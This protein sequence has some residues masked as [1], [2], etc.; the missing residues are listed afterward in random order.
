M[1]EGNKE[2]YIFGIIDILTGY[3]T[4]KAMEFYFKR[5]FYGPGISAVPPDQY[6]ERF[7]NFAEQ[8]VFKNNKKVINWMELSPK[9]K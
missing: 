7:I 8:S 1:Y 6:A 9:K 3:D 5:V 4:K 2:S